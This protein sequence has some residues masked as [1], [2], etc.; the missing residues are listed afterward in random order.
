M[1]EKVKRSVS[2]F[3]LLGSENDSEMPQLRELI[4]LRSCPWPEA[5]I[6]SSGVMLA[7]MPSVLT[8]LAVDIYQSVSR[9]VMS[10]IN[11]QIVTGDRNV[12]V[13]SFPS[14]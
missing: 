2:V 1:T 6:L 14:P 9:L 13:V 8:T 7:S 12:G 3:R 11:K 5:L 4:N 10:Q